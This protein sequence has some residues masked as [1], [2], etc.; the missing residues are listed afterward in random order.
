QPDAIVC[1]SDRPIAKR[2]KEKISA[3][4]DVPEEGIVS[5][6]DAEILYEIPL[7]LHD[8]GRLHDLDGI[9]VPGGFGI[10]GI[11][12]KIAAAGYAREA[13]I[14]FLGLCLGLHCAVIE[15][16]RDECGLAGANSS[17]FDPH[18]PHPVI[19]L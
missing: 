3:L 11:E 18:S 12:G 8:E 6:V 15:F 4:C 16:A 19:D 1:R 17:E 10:R 14:P 7:V 9:V 5:A 2:L 13:G